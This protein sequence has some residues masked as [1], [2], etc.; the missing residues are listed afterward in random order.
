MKS[1]RYPSEYT[2]NDIIIDLFL[3]EVLFAVLKWAFFKI[4]RLLFP[5]VFNTYRFVAFKVNGKVVA[6]SPKMT[7]NISSD[8]DV[9]AVYKLRIAAPLYILYYK[10]LIKARPIRLWFREAYGFLENFLHK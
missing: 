6:T 2:L 4:V 1:Q 8:A 5:K 7:L 3:K 10:F 9:L